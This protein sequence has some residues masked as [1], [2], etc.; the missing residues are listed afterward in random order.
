[1]GLNQNFNI[2][3]AEDWIIE[4]IGHI[5]R[6]EQKDLYLVAAAVS[7]L[8]VEMRKEMVFVRE[9]LKKIREG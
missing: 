6:G 3:D 9:E 1:M 5:N 7:A 2:G 4:A 8:V